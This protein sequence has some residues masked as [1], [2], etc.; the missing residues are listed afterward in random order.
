MNACYVQSIFRLHGCFLTIGLLALMAGCASSR[1][2][3]HAEV[4][5]KVLFQGQPL[6]GGKIT[7]VSVNGGYS[8]VGTI[9]ENGAYQIKAPVGEVE[10]G[11]TNRILRP[12]GGATG[13]IPRLAKAQAGENQ[14]V[15]GRW[16][17]IPRQYED[18]HKSGLK[19]TVTR[20]PQTHDV[21]LSANPG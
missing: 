9:D 7:F 20:G 4:S 16:V 11:V 2:P 3:Q 18:P 17:Q 12:R 6:P 13:G 10:I 15:K 14:P 1:T 5:G 8:S 19:Y 21:E